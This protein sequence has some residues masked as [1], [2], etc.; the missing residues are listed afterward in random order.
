MGWPW[1]FPGWF[2]NPWFSTWTWI[3][4]WGPW[5]NPYGF[6]YFS[7]MVVYRYYPAR[8]YGLRHLSFVPRSGAM[9]PPRLGLERG[10]G[11]GAARMDRPL[12]PRSGW[13]A[14]APAMRA[15]FGRMGMGRAMGGRR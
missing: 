4:T 14:H 5:I 1:G 6:P 13:G 11:P 12:G 15:P 8:Y 10:L 2:W 9:N 7:P 3:P